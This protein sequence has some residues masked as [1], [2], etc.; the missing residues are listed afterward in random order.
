M[1]EDVYRI[2]LMGTQGTGKS[3]LA[4]SVA[5]LLKERGVESIAL[6]EKSQ[7]ARKIGLNINEETD[8]GSQLWILHQTF[9]DVIDH[10]VRRPGCDFSVIISDR[11]PDN[12]CYLKKAHGEDI[13]ALGMVIGHMQRFPYSRSYLLPIVDTEIAENNVRSSDKD[14][15]ETMDRHIR[16]FL[17]D[18]RM[19]YVE[20]PQPQK[21]DTFR[22]EWKKI[23]INKT[24]SDLNHPEK[25]FIK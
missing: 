10:S 20:L 22:N 18:Q 14:F 21:D 8:A 16:R 12:Y 1:S 24:L 7:A 25:Y 5:G 13:Y 2:C 19:E 11:G 17:H 6:G 9:A 15:Q 3:A 4:G 23:I